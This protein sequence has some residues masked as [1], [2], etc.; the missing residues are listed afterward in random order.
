[1]KKLGEGTD[2]WHFLHGMQPIF[3]KDT[4]AQSEKLTVSMRANNV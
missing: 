4:N 3:C 2:C 1:M